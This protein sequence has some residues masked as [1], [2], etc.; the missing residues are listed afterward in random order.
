[1]PFFQRLFEYVCMNNQLVSLKYLATKYKL[2]EHDVD[3]ND[4][5][6][7]DWLHDDPQLSH[8]IESHFG[9]DLNSDFLV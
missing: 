9:F 7:Y 4:F 2:T 6:H 8:F 5:Q 1:M 3:I